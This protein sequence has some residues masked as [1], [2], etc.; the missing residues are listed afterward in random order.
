[1]PSENISILR[2]FIME[3]GSILGLCWIAVFACYVVGFRTQNGIFMLSG[4]MG[5]VGL[6][7]VEFFLGCRIKKR[8]VQ[9]EIKSSFFFTYMN[10]LGIFMYACLLCGCLEYIYFAFIDK[11]ALFEAIQTM[12]DSTEIK[13]L[14]TQMGMSAYYKQITDTIDE[15]SMLSAFEKAMILFNQN[16]A[17]GLFMSVP[18]SIAAHF[19]RPAMLK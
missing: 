14:Y 10:V 15:L 7:A 11:G 8:S 9:L 6:L 5:L 12:L 3:Y 19:Y 18:V 1:M 13:Q 17:V 2:K 16:F 4:L